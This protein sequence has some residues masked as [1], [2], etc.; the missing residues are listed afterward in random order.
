MGEETTLKEDNDGSRCF[1]N[2]LKDF[3][4]AISGRMSQKGI[5]CRTTTEN[6]I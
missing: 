1:E 3:S 6:K 4:L 5:E 2:Y